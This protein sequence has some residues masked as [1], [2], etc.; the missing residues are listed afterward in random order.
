MLH[1][2]I[3][4]DFSASFNRKYL[5]LSLMQDFHLEREV[6]DFGRLASYFLKSFLEVC[7]LYFLG[8]IFSSWK[9][10]GTVPVTHLSPTGVVEHLQE[11]HLPTIL[12]CEWHANGS[13][14]PNNV[15]LISSASG[16]GVSYYPLNSYWWY[17]FVTVQTA[18]DWIQNSKTCLRQEPWPE[19]SFLGLAA[20]SL[21]HNACWEWGS[22][23]LITVASGYVQDSFLMSLVMSETV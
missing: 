7:H 2:Q 15:F 9:M 12:C 13:L 17:L 22:K 11:V 6:A 3:P 23:V 21:L 5:D 1:Q 20:G 16:K 10:G 18:L 8:F 19:N 14:W 4:K